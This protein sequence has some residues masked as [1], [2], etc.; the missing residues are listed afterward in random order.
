MGENVGLEADTTTA[1]PLCPECA[2][3]VSI[4]TDAIVSEIVWCGDCGSELE[5][6]GRDPILLALAPEVEEDW[7]E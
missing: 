3:P 5:I 2:R 7:G 6:V 4:R 1:A